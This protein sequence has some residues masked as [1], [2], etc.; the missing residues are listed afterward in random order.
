MSHVVLAQRGGDPQL[1]ERIHEVVSVDAVVF[2][3]TTSSFRETV[4]LPD[5]W[6]AFVEQFDAAQTELTQL[7]EQ[8]QDARADRVRLQEQLAELTRRNRI[9]DELRAAGLPEFAITPAFEGQLEHIENDLLRHRLIA[10]RVELSR[11]LRP[12]VPAS[13]SRQHGQNAS[14]DAFIRAVRAK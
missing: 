6:E 11:R 9:R 10:E 13:Q 3:A 12:S 4:E 5:S 2:P 8:L 14:D 7:R 1:V